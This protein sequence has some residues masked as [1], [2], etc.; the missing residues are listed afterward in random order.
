MLVGLLFL[1]VKVLRQSLVRKHE[2]EDWV[3][4]GGLGR[5]CGVSDEEFTTCPGLQARN[6]HRKSQSACGVLERDRFFSGDVVTAE[7]LIDNSG[8]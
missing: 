6:T 1:D 7:K 8:L 3:R 5:D 4:K 2:C